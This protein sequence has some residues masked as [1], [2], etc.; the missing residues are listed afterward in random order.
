M[1]QALNFW[2]R[3][4]FEGAWLVLVIAI[5]T[6]L[7]TTV[8]SIA[9]SVW[10][11]RLPFADPAKLVSVGWTSEADVS[12]MASTSTEEFQDLKHS[13]SELFDLAA[14]EAGGRWF[15]R[16]ETA[17]VEVAGTSV[18][19]NLFDV[20]GVQA[21]RGRTFRLGD[22]DSNGTV[23]VVSDRL[24]RARF[25]ADPGIVGRVV[26]VAVGP[27]EERAIQIVGVLPP[28]VALRQTGLREMDLMV[29]V[30]DGLRPGGARSRR[31]LDRVLLARL[32]SGVT[33]EAAE[34]RLTSVFQAIDREFPLS[35]R[36]RTAT[37]VGLHE[38]WFGRSKPF[39]WL[40][41][42]V[43][44]FLL[45]VAAA[46]AVGVMLALASR[47]TREMAV[48][49]AIGAGR[50]HLVR[51]A[52]RESGLVACI[53]GVLSLVIAATL[54]RLFVA[55]APAD[56]PRLAEASLDWSGA[57]LATFLVAVFCVFL[58][59][60]PAVGRRHR[61]VVVA[62]QAGGTT[63][64]ASRQTLVVR[65]FAIAV[66]LAVVL[67]LLAAA[68]LVSAT[69]WRMLAQ[70]LGFDPDRVVVCRVTPTRPY[71]TDLPRYQQVMNDV[72]REAELA[73]GSSAALTLDPPL[74]DWSS[75]MRVGFLD[76]PPAFVATKF[77]SEGFFGTM[78]IPLLAGRD[79][80]R[81]DLATG[82]FVIVNEMFARSFFGGA[83][84][85]VGREIDFGTRQL[86]VGVVG[87]VREAG[88]VV[89]LAP[90][91][92][93]VL[94]T[95]ARRTPGAFYVVMRPRDDSPNLMRG[96]EQAIRRTDPSLHVE[97]SVLTDRLRAQ[98][99]IAK[100]LATAIGSLALCSVLLAALGIYAT[101]AQ[102]VGDRQRE[103]AIRS[104]LGASR[105]S[106]V[107]LAARGIGIPAMAGLVGGGLLS[108]T[109][110]R[111]TRQFLFE[112]TPFDPTI[113]LAAAVGLVATAGAA[114]WW[115]A[116][117]AATLDP[118]V[119]LRDS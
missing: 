89:P 83:E 38:H 35:T 2:L 57:L 18:T 103:M 29:A 4:R 81:S 115:P 75:Q 72:R 53:A 110:A 99:A 8:W 10:F 50:A 24:W 32:R 77:V 109:I 58:G 86:V 39:L 22:A 44:G 5:A 48:R 1:R 68:G 106:L 66:Q 9:D 92:Y 19:T 84:K 14:W 117:R 78:H 74:A 107:V 34:A 33:A 88:L 7:A 95:A 87:N 20:L 97:V 3:H 113:W 114:A 11:E 67:A 42:A 62:L 102:V 116:R 30:P 12:R 79:F 25:N 70:P 93:P 76:R 96:I 21:A 118:A 119:V 26:A 91:L 27:L 51:Q 36:T 108:W 80:Q 90:V 47:R 56:V 15:L 71:F 73:A 55:F 61:D 43:A 46:N 41:A 49:T 63:S 37:I 13:T 64:T 65:R 23:A 104:T 54:V 94:A 98:T 111:V 28:R 52:L 82:E 40:L 60:V 105:R 85:A 100:T 17:L 101:V 31:S 69:L 6:G 16:S 59:L 112:M 45:L